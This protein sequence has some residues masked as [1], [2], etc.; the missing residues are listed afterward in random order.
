M[1]ICGQE[2]RGR[3]GAF[4]SFVEKSED[5]SILAFNYL[6]ALLTGIDRCSFEVATA[7][8][9]IGADRSYLPSIFYVFCLCYSW[10]CGASAVGAFHQSSPLLNFL[11][12]YEPLPFLFSTLDP[13][14]LNARYSW[15]SSPDFLNILRSKSLSL[16]LILFTSLS[17]CNN[18]ITK[19]VVC[20]PLF[21]IFLFYFSISVKETSVHP[22]EQLPIS[23]LKPSSS[24]SSIKY[25]RIAPPHQLR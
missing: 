6:I 5:F 16:F 9:L 8:A 18:Y 10:L 17:F 7:S 24:N 12:L 15:S 23:F 11:L 13:L 22:S 1:E 19:E 14:R 3:A 25:V 21:E 4:Q 20:Q 2:D